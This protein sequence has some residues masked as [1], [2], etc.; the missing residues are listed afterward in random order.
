M[1]FLA[2]SAPPG[3]TAHWTSDVNGDILRPTVEDKLRSNAGIAG[4]LI[5]GTSG[6]C[7]CARVLHRVATA[8]SILPHLLHPDRDCTRMAAVSARFAQ[9]EDG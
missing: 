5:L 8:R 7:H 6:H 1:L 4:Y 3:A 2:I 9:M